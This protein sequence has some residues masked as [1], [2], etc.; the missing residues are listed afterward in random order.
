[1]RQF[2]F[3]CA[4]LVAL[5]SLAFA[6]FDALLTATRTKDLEAV[7]TLLQQGSDPNPPYDSYDGYTPLM[8]SSQNGD[9][10]M[11]RLLIEA[12][13]QT[14]RRDH[15]GERALEWATS[16]HYL[17]SFADVPGCVRLLL[18]AGSPAD[19]DG[20]RFGVSPLMHASHYGGHA[21]LIR[22]LLEAGADPNRIDEFNETALHRA[23]WQ[24]G[25]AVEMLLAAG[26]D[27]NI[28]KGTL[29]RT[30][31][32]Q[33]A[34]GSATGNARLLL[35]AGAETEP[36]YYRDQTALFIAAATGADG[37]VEA[38]LD[39]GAFVDAADEDGLTPILAA[40]GGVSHAAPERRA[41]AVLLLAERTADRDRGFAAAIGGAFDAAAERLL[42]RGASV[43]A[44][45]QHGRA[46]L[47]AA[48]SRAEPAWFERLILEGVDLAR[49]G[50]DALG[51]AA[52]QGFDD[53]LVRLFEFG[54][55]VDARDARGATA[56][57]RASAGGRVETVEMLLR[58]GAD[59][60]A[61]DDA[62]RD[63]GASMAAARKPYELAIAHA[64]GS[65]AFIDVSGERAAL[66]ALEL[67]HARIA[68]ILGL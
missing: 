53:R 45:D 37:V 3:A 32:H 15:N 9:T 17:H 47:A 38:L 7:R 20:D 40:I 63:A 30:P 50:G 8:F 56:L 48:A 12:G 16:A 60:A 43:D 22:M 59:R 57:L 23:A 41:G 5:P 36:R 51:E 25:T 1:M 62:G 65:R 49:H 2:V 26:T 44:V 18:D 19:S 34:S 14:E 31:L 68:A 6:S 33:A 46:A 55:D 64:E 21:D 27:P 61:Q 10:E 58:R 11:T 52:E 66:A 39:A 67:A 35:D 42:A 24:D 29:G 4:L 13:A 54:I 28:A